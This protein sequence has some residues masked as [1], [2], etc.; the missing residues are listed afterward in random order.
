MTTEADK[1]SGGIELKTPKELQIM[2]RAGR[3]VSDLLKLMER[4][5]RS[6]ISVPAEGYVYIMAVPVRS[7]NFV[8]R[9]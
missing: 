5:I 3:V 8:A 7:T 2:R 6:G 1:F 9:Q 4:E